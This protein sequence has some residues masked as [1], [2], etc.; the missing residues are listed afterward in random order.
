[1]R[2]SAIIGSCILLL[3]FFGGTSCLHGTGGPP[4]SVDTTP[5]EPINSKT[6]LVDTERTALVISDV[7][8]WAE[9]WKRDYPCPGDPSVVAGQEWQKV[10]RRQLGRTT[11]A[12]FFNIS[13]N[14]RDVYLPDMRLRIRIVHE[15]DGYVHAL[16]PEAFCTPEFSSSE[17]PVSLEIIAVTNE[18]S[19]TLMDRVQEYAQKYICGSYSTD[20]MDQ[21]TLVL[22]RIE[23]DE[24]STFVPVSFRFRHEKSEEAVLW[25]MLDYSSSEHSYVPNLKK[26]GLDLA[27]LVPVA[28]ARG[29]RKISFTCD[30]DARAT[31]PR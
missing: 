31:A 27:F 3:T 24:P 17:S 26:V 20:P 22:P 18:P 30:A 5:P 10:F 28:E 11:T 15:Q 2:K 25:I 16:E 14:G 13:T 21:F 23:T 8:A 7:L 1:M 6:N 9:R 4:L 12:Y 29:H 19:R